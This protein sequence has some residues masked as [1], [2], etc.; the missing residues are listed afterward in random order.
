MGHKDVLGDKLKGLERL[1]A[2]RKADPY[3][4]L[5]C[6]IDGKSFSK[7]TKGLKRPFDERFVRLM[8]E[9]TRHLVEETEANLGYCQSDE[10]SLYW[11]LEKREFSN[12]EF[13]FGGKF[14]KIASVTASIASSFFSANLPKHLPE[15][16][17]LYPAFD[18]RVWS[19]PD[20]E[21]VHENFAWRRLDAKKNS[22][23]MQA[24]H[25]FSHKSLQGKSS[26]EMK[27]LLEEI[28]ESWRDLP[29]FFREGTYLRRQTIS[30]QPE[31]PIFSGLPEKYKP[32]GP[33]LR[34]VVKE[35]MPKEGE[36]LL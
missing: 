3:L 23:S 29:V 9:T 31:D 27:A 14:Q 25:F 36:L 20:L 2:G 33:V 22:V 16:A 32:D 35:W 34:T 15:K 26:R 30:F 12:R 8:V 18:S 7:F 17:G 28:G 11:N 5:M 10:I 13:W 19:V 24:R 21:H 1:E 6:R 4:P